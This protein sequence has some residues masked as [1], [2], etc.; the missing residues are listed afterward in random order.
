MKIT[1]DTNV[2]LRLVLADDEAQGLAA[3]K[4]MEGATLVAISLQALCELSWVME[5][6]YKT[7]RPDI[8]AAI[9][10]LIEAEHVVVNRAAVEAGLAIFDVG[11]DFADGVIA[12][13]GRFHGGETFVTFD[14]KAVKLLKANGDAALLLA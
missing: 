9:R 14:R 2:L 7:A 13:D 8:A 1:A 3:V 5:R 12:F 4:A 6:L 11:G 10:S